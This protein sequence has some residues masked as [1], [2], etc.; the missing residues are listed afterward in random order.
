MLQGG[1]TS[2]PSTLTLRDL[3]I[4][5]PLALAPMV[6][7]SHSALRT[8]IIEL[9]GV[10]MLYTEM[11]SARKLPNENAAVSPYLIR[12]PEETPLF[13]QL[14]I[15]D[16]EDAAPAVDKLALLDAQGIDI[17]L[18]CPAP[19]VRKLGAGCYLANDKKR[20][21][22]L[23]RRLR[24][25]TERVVSVKIRLGDS[26]DEAALVEFC[27]MLEGEGI[28]L[29]TVHG[30]LNKEKFC[31][32]PRW[33]MIGKVKDSLK[34]P[35]IANGGIFSVADAQHCLAVSGADG[36][37]IGRAAAHHPW[38]F[39]DIAQE[40]YGTTKKR[41]AVGKKEIYFRFID[42]LEQRFP[43][44]RRLGRLKKFTHYFSENFA[45]G[46]HFA[47]C[48]QKAGSVDQVRERA[49]QF[50]STQEKLTEEREKI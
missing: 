22:A 17:N 6:G 19:S 14:L 33:H 7:L 1:H 3:Q 34:I 24:S 46:H 18:G 28:D 43:Q 2:H 21:Q 16:P 47:H 35:V 42:L 50:F 31:R 13:Y 48:I 29:L 26:L 45:F 25:C 23:L 38:L 49:G 12:G 30:R 41:R 5:P 4:S 44:E 36:L 15:T 8:L 9:G 10:G 40:I 20:V 39:A 37:M 32:K 27:R 11:L